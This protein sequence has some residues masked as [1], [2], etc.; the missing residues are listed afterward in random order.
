[1]CAHARTQRSELIRSFS[2]T[3]VC[4][5]IA[6]PYSLLIRSRILHALYRLRCMR[7]PTA[8]LYVSRISPRED[9]RSSRHCLSEIKLGRCFEGDIFVMQ[10]ERTMYKI[11][12]RQSI[13]RARARTTAQYS[14]QRVFAGNTLS[15]SSI[16]AIT[17]KEI[18]NELHDRSDVRVRTTK[19][20]FDSADTI[21][22]RTHAFV[23]GTAARSSSSG[24]RAIGPRCTC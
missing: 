3:R 5:R 17:Q 2:V 9:K 8:I 6:K 15:S 20:I 14:V 22:V 18:I 24:K 19:L 16:L 23:F 21:I 12:F 13:E 4:I 1:M 10:R 11:L 7:A